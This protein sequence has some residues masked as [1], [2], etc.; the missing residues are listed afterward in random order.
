MQFISGLSELSQTPIIRSICADMEAEKG[1][2]TP[3]VHINKS[4]FFIIII[5]CFINLL[6][7][8]VNVAY[9]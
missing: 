9:L 2:G 8:Y 5:L 3:S 6:L 4:T 1:R 7:N